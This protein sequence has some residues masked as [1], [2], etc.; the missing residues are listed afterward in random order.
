M[1]ARLD[2][3]A[4]EVEVLAAALD[5]Y[6]PTS[7]VDRAAAR[8]I[9]GRLASFP[10]DTFG[11]F[12]GWLKESD[13]FLCEVRACSVCGGLVSQEPPDRERHLAWHQRFAVTEGKAHRL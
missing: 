6:Y 4:A 2:L 8:A 11:P 3:T 12:R 5:H 10:P 7:Q 13:D 9:R 1:E